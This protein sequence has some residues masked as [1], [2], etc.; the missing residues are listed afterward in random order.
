[1]CTLIMSGYQ[2]TPTPSTRTQ[3]QSPAECL[4]TIRRNIF[5]SFRNVSLN[6]FALCLNETL[7]EAF[8]GDTFQDF[9]EVHCKF[10]YRQ[11]DILITN[12]TIKYTVYLS[13]KYMIA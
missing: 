11:F 6:Q 13:N 12:N 5:N 1:M 3:E 9:T 10:D 7:D 8:S 2:P 4:A